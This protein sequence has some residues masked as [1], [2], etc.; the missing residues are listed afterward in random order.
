MVFS[1]L[2]CIQ[3][4]GKMN[5][6]KQQHS[7]LI[8]CQGLILRHCCGEL[9]V[10]IIPD[11][12]QHQLL[13]LNHCWWEQMIGQFLMTPYP[14]LNQ[15]HLQGI[16]HSFW[17]FM[18]LW[19]YNKNT[20]IIMPKNVYPILHGGGDILLLINRLNDRPAKGLEI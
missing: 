16:S 8:P 15:K 11:L 6:E 18:A 9:G 20:R 4:S 3:Q 17:Y 13:L 12:L 5:N 19:I 7:S 10:L 1:I 14:V 2:G